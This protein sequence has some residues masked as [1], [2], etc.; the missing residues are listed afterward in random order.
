[1]QEEWNTA[2]TAK[3]TDRDHVRELHG[4]GRIANATKFPRG[5]GGRRYLRRESQESKRQKKRKKTNS[6]KKHASSEY[7]IPSRVGSSFTHVQHSR[8][9]ERYYGIVIRETRLSY[10]VRLE[11][12]KPP[13][14]R[15]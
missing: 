15:E 1:M 3:S 6:V 2:Q 8:D 11:E 7:G 13:T 9:R 5:C 14:S 10:T 12:I 4:R